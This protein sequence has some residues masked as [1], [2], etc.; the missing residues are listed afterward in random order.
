[1]FIGYNIVQPARLPLISI[2]SMPCKAPKIQSTGPGEFYAEAGRRDLFDGA[3]AMGLSLRWIY[4]SFSGNV[5]IGG[6]HLLLYL[7]Q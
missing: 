6:R 1:M 4:F 2:S 7:H 3:W 5:Q